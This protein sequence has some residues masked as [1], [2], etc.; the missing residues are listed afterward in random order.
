MDT[1]EHEGARLLAALR[2]T[3]PVGCD[4]PG[5]YVARAIR[6]G[7]RTVRARR[8]LAVVGGAVAVAMIALV[9]VVLATPSRDGRFGPAAGGGFDVRERTFRVGS[10]GGYT[11][12][13]YETGRFRQ[14]V[15]LGPEKPGAAPELAATRA[16]VTMYAAGRFPATASAAGAGA[17]SVRE[18]PAVWLIGPTPVDGRLELAWQWARDA[19]AVV[20]L[21]G[22]AADAE[23]ARHIAESVLPGSR[24]PVR[25]PLTLDPGALASGE[26]VVAVIAPMAPE[27]SSLYALRFGTTD[28]P[29]AEGGDP[30]SFVVG[31]GATPGAHDVPP[32]RISRADGAFAE[33]EPAI[34]ANRLRALL[35]AIR[36]IDT[37]SIQPT[38]VP[39]DG[40]STAAAPTTSPPTSASGSPTSTT[41]TAGNVDGAATSTRTAGGGTPDAPDTFGPSSTSMSATATMG[42]AR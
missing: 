15:T 13:S 30:A 4:E 16:T 27:K 5:V 33:S 34:E 23:R 11:P 25:V 38:L 1:E 8:A 12:V 9:T 20:S 14:R 35:A 31:V 6:D 37:A 26:H 18:R 39:S 7:R 36:L 28:P 42:S 22:P 41:D 24:V 21:T 19:W 17:P 29:N 40:A 10:A 32:D 3:P 2:E